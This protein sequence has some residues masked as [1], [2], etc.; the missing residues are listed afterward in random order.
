MDSTG[1]HRWVSSDL[2]SGCFESGWIHLHHL[3]AILHGLGSHERDELHLHRCRN[4]RHR[5]GPDFHAFESRHPG[6][7]SGGSDSGAG[8][9]VVHLNHGHLPQRI[10]ISKGFLDCTARDERGGDFVLHGHSHSSRSRSIDGSHQLRS[11]DHVRGDRAHE[12]QGVHILC[13][14]EQQRRHFCRIV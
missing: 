6:W 7:S 3:C 14:R 12:W 9:G 8:S 11:G 4:E 2:V 1:E 13:H 10:E 5:F